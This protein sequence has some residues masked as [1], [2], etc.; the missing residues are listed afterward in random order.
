MI[1]DP[2]TEM[3]DRP[4]FKI[5]TWYQLLRLAAEVPITGKRFLSRVRRYAGGMHTF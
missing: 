3:T 4:L 1:V 2:L 5:L